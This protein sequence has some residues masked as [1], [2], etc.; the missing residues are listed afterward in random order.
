M[1]I[2]AE[3]KQS[4]IVAL[5]RNYSFEDLKLVSVEKLTYTYKY[6]SFNKAKLDKA[7]GEHTVAGGGKVAVY[8][9]PNVGKLGV[10]PANNAVR[11]IDQTK[12]TS[13]ADDSHLGHVEVTP[14]LSKAFLQAAANPGLR[15]AYC[16]KLWEHLNKT[17]FQGKLPKPN[18]VVSAKSPS[19]KSARGVYIGGPM[20]GAGQVWMAAFMFDSREPF[21]L[22]VFLHE[23][24][25]QA[26]WCISQSTDRSQQGHGPI[27]QGWMR[28]VGL[29]PR[30]FDPTDAQEYLTG[31]A[32]QALE[33]EYT[34]K[35][36]ARSSDTEIKE[37]TK[38]PNPVS[39]SRYVIVQNGRIV[40]GELKGKTFTGVTPN[41][42]TF[43]WKIKD[44]KTLT[45]YKDEQ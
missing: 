44:L 2:E 24:C 14:A 10:S 21:F 30:R 13:K 45:F 8:Q 17:K 35:Y 15:V 29:D 39:G 31:P 40:R 7:L 42:K 9:I 16:T 5:L 41:N 43:E 38:V 32:K 22:E 12:E 23:L 36:G 18:F 26:A 3:L 11:M 34:K 1:K 20:Y 25:H 4:E 28:K 33:L 27:W 19:S 6:S 37:L